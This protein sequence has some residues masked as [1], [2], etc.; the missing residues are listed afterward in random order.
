VGTPENHW[1]LV[2][3]NI[4]D[5]QELAEHEVDDNSLI[6]GVV[7]DRSEVG[8]RVPGSV[9]QVKHQIVIILK[10]HPRSPPTCSNLKK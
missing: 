9:G 1:V 3:S 10:E 7:F 2:C 5:F 6:W 4:R 8:G